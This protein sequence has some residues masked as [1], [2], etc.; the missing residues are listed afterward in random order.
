[1]KRWLIILLSTLAALALLA[2]AC[3]FG[4]LI[5]AAG[6][7][8]AE[9]PGGIFG[10]GDTVAVIP[11]EGVI[12]GGDE[13]GDLL[14]AGG[15]HSERVIRDLKRAQRDPTVKAVVLRVDSPGG[16]VTASEEIHRE[17]VRTKD[18]YHKKIVV[19][20]GSLAASGGYYVSAPADKIVANESTL[21]GSI[22][23]ILTLPV[24]RGLLDK[25]GLDV[26]VFKSGAHKDDTAGLRELTPE[27]RKLLQALVD[28]SYNQ[29]VDVVASGRHLDR[30]KVLEL[31][32]GRVYT[33]RQARENGLVDEL[34]GEDRA[35]EVAAQLAGLKGKPRVQRYRPPGLLTALT[36]T[37]YR[38]SSEA[39][40]VQALG[41]DP[42]PRLEYLYSAR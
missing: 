10:L 40:L 28:D 11:V 26:A 13:G 36:S 16:G 39:V 31:A 24:V 42:T 27:D 8:G 18:E 14:S 4:V 12:S 6:G 3:S 35:I 41:L 38:P 20:M 17:V 2:G 25:V 30:N 22:G 37:F 33:G 23:V 5:G 9:S 15:A 21:T 7:G 19:S 32:D 1:M 34:G 29:F